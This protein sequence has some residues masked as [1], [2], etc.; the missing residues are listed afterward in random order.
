[1]KTVH[2]PVKIITVFL[3]CILLL[4]GC[5]LESDEQKAENYYSLAEQALQNDNQNDAL[6]WLQK[7]IQKNNDLGKAHYQLGHLYR[8]MGKINLA[9]LELNQAISLDPHDKKAKKELAF[10]L[11]EQNAPNRTLKVCRQYLKEEGSDP[12]IALIMGNA[13]LILKKYDEAITFLQKSVRE[14][15]DNSP[16]LVTLSRALFATGAN[17]EARQLMEKTAREFPKDIKVQLALSSLY[18]QLGLKQLQLQSL[19]QLTTDFPKKSEPYIART[20]Y[21]LQQQA[22]DKALSILEKAI[23]S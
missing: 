16:L 18:E 13:L 4:T 21:W 23:A 2:L 8:K 14:Y 11:A 20:R 5:F 1:M 9:Y 10:F 22:P 19:K 17:K 12:D 7:A 15:P 3:P 6:I